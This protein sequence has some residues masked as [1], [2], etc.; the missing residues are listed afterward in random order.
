MLTHKNLRLWNE[1]LELVKDIYQA[2]GK[3]PKTEQFGLTDQIRR[4]AVSVVSNISE[5]AGRMQ[6]GEF[7]YFLR[8]ASG[9]LSEVEVQLLIS[10]ELGFLDNQEFDSMNGKVNLI[11]AQLSGLLKFLKN[12]KGKKD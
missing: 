1:S 12:Q 11:R 2:T 10:K 4:A 8:I 9:S 6:N 5:G 7:Q 3:F